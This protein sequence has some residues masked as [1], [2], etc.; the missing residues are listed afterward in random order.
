VNRVLTIVGAS[1]RAA[2]CSAVRAGYHVRAADLFADADLCRICDA[3]RIGNYP[4]GLSAVLHAQQ[5]GAWMYTGALE[6]HPSLVESLS[7]ARPLWGNP[8]AVLRRVRNPQLVAESLG[9]G[10]LCCPPVSFDPRTVPRDGSWLCKPRRSAGGARIAFWN[11][12]SPPV[13]RV[14]GRYF[15]QFVDGL[16]CSAVYVAARGH[17]ALLGVTRQL[18]GQTWTGAS[19]FRYCGSIGPIELP[20]AVTDSFA[21]IGTVLAREFKL[22]GL[23]GV[24]AIVTGAGVWPVEVNPR[25]TASVEILERARSVPAIALHAAACE[26]NELPSR[27]EPTDKLISGK[28]ILFAGSPLEISAAWTDLAL[29]ANHRCPPMLADIPSAG[30]V[31]EAGSPIVTVFADAADEAAVFDLLHRQAADVLKTAGHEVGSS[32]NPAAKL[33]GHSRA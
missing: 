33:P 25:Y 7:R 16:A 19:G 24:D 17:A 15:Q 22:V 14:R 30:T 13:G 2:A 11:H 12:E 20:L 31:I 10:G 27:E 29:A 32:D 8:A 3:T 4:S 9:H 6:N 23:F 26:D 5:T 21:R 18:I 28:A 1:A